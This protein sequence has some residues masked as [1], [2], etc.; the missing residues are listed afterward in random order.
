[1][2]RLS[3]VTSC[4]NYHA[5]VWDEPVVMQLGDPGRRGQVFRQARCSGGH[6]Q[7]RR[8]RSA[9][10][11]RHW[12]RTTP[13]ALP[14]MTEPEVQR[15]YLHL[16]PGNAGHGEHQP[17]RHLHHE[18]QCPRQRGAWRSAPFVAEVHPLQ[19]D[20]THAGHPRDHPSTSISACA[21]SPA[22]TSSSSR[23]AAA[24]MPPIPIACVTR[25][26]HKSRGE[27]GK[28]NEII[29]SIQAHPCNA[30]TAA[31]AGFKVDHAQSRGEW[32]SLDSRR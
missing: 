9:D 4:G 27:L 32:L 3:N 16:S 13:P 21:N 30:A 6:S 18:I 8:S 7:G 2:S 12:R 25:A 23:P 29:T 17:L 20:D 24:P 28:R 26:Y 19:P 11:R 10:P 14:E 31:A 22:W 5:A 15:H 1:M